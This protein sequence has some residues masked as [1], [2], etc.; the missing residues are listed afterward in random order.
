MISLFKKF[1]VLLIL[2][3]IATNISSSEATKKLSCV[4]VNSAFKPKNDISLG[5]IQTSQAPDSIT[6]EGTPEVTDLQPGAE[7]FN[8]HS[9]DKS[10]TLKFKEEKKF[11][12]FEVGK[13]ELDDVS[14]AIPLLRFYDTRG[15]C[16]TQV[17]VGDIAEVAKNTR[18]VLQG[19][20]NRMAQI[21]SKQ[22]CA[23]LP[24]PN[25]AQVDSNL[26]KF[27]LTLNFQSVEFVGSPQ[28]VETRNYVFG[29]EIPSETIIRKSLQEVDL[30]NPA[31]A[32]C[33]IDLKDGWTSIISVTKT[34]VASTVKPV[35]PT[36]GVSPAAG[37]P[38]DNPTIAP[39]S[40]TTTTSTASQFLL[41][42]IGGAV[43]FLAWIL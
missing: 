1:A 3:S 28:N 26:L 37:Q 41:T 23:A 31:D 19:C 32:A 14:K 21:S 38:G 25:I 33:T 39:K 13:L 30:K 20:E 15:I 4:H 35:T 24:K 29:S 8:I 10:F 18:N 36:I 17:M 2:G 27:E 12:S 7:K 5:V 6:I 11:L 34:L 9:Q 40:S 43:I 16:I 22:E 42:G